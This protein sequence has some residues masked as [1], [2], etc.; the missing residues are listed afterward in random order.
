MSRPLGRAVRGGAVAVAVATVL[1]GCAPTGDDLTRSLAADLVEHIVDELTPPYPTPTDAQ[2]LAAG[3]ASAAATRPVGDP[4][5]ARV[6]VLDWHGHSGDEDG[7][8]I[9]I[10]VEV[11]VAASRATTIGQ[12]SHEAGDAT[13]CWDVTIW[14]FRNYDTSRL[15]EVDCPDGAPALQPE[16]VTPTRLPDDAEH[17]LVEVLAPVT[18]A[19]DAVSALRAHYPEEHYTVEAADRAE[20]VV[21]AFGLPETRD[22][23]LAIRA[24]DG[25]VEVG[26]GW[27]DEW[28]RP[29]E[30]GCSPRLLDV[31]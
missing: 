14:G 20:G 21:L 31:R 4:D 2:N 8:V 10:R 19:A 12:G 7:A 30:A 9:R 11:H 26:G 18:T 24:D 15:D 16:R 6:A 5:E 17:V 29:G 22:C 23:L 3:V 28:L 1:A 25:T 13:R 27:P